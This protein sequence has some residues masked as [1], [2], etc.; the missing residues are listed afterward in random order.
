MLP[1]TSSPQSPIA[2]LD[3]ITSIEQTYFLMLEVCE[4]ILYSILIL[5]FFS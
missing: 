4:S 5:D 1:T 3:P 2:H